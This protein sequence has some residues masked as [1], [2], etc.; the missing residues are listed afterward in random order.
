MGPSRPGPRRDGNRRRT[1]SRS[2]GRPNE[3]GPPG[4]GRHP[5]RTD[6]APSI[7]RTG[8]ALGAALLVICLVAA[9]GDRVRRPDRAERRGQPA[10]NDDARR[11]PRRRGAL[12]HRL[13]VRGRR[14]GVRIVDATPRDPVERREGRRLDAPATRPRD[15]AAAEL[16]ARCGPRRPPPVRRRAHE[17]PD[18]RPRRHRPARRRRGGR[19]VGDRRTASGSRPMPPRSSTSTPR[20]RRSSWPRCSTP[21]RPAARGQA[22]RRRDAGPRHDP[23]RQPLGAA[24]HPGPRQDRRPSAS[25]PTSTS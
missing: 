16:R 3:T 4:P 10:A 2:L 18:R 20:A 15:R 12:R 6:D 22:S 13:P 1:A 9:P 21:T 11:L 25:T 8:A 24:A 7:G 23:D 19:R 17:G 14:R 5:G